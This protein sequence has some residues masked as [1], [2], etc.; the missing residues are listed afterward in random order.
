MRDD[1][2]PV[3]GRYGFADVRDGINRLSNYCGA[4]SN[5]L[6]KEM[7]NGGRLATGGTYDLKEREQDQSLWCVGPA[8]DKKWEIQVYYFPTDAEVCDWVDEMKVSCVDQ[9]NSPSWKYE[10]VRLVAKFITVESSVSEEVIA[11]EFGSAYERI[12][13]AE[14]KTSTLEGW[15]ASEYD[16]DVRCGCGHSASIRNSDIMRRFS[17]AVSLPEAQTRLKCSHCGTKGSARLRPFFR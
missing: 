6:L 11:A 5:S 1:P 14:S 15:A 17:P 16:M 4:F 8:G 3:I 9:W 13:D 7:K 10:K 2:S 12:L